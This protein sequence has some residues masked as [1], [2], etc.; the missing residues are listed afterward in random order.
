MVALD[1]IDG[2]RRILL[3][4]PGSQPPAIVTSIAYALTR[5]G[6]A[7]ET[8]LLSPR[9]PDSHNIELFL[10][11]SIQ[12]K[13]DIIGGFSLGARLAIEVSQ[14]KK[15]RAVLAMGF[16]FHRRSHPQQ[17]HGLQGLQ[18]QQTPTLVLQGSRDCHGSESEFRGYAPLPPSIALHWLPN[19]NHRWLVPKST[20]AERRALLQSAS[21]ATLQFLSSLVSPH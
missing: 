9:Q 8:L 11:R 17:T 3:A 18:R 13:A 14:R 7:V 21:E 1:D 6:Y 12:S 2:G 20:E 15:V 10:D 19:A 4:A 5:G 16:P